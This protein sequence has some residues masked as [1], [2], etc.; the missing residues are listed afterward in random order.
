V[1]SGRHGG[2]PVGRRLRRGGGVLGAVLWL[3]A[4]ARDAHRGGGGPGSQAM[5]G[6]EQGREGGGSGV[7][8]DGAAA[9]LRHARLAALRRYSGERRDARDVGR[10]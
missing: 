9:R 6:V 3:E 4:E 10:G 8:W 7:A 5:R 1:G 2:V